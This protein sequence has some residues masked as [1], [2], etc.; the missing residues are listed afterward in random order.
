[1][2]Q[3]EVDE[4]LSEISRRAEWIAL[5]ATSSS[6]RLLAGADVPWLIGLIK[7]AT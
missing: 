5:H 6:E 3:E 1:M 2:T 7:E 4:R